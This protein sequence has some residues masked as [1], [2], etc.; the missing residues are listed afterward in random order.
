MKYFMVPCARMLKFEMDWV[1][2]TTET[3]WTSNNIS[4]RRRIMVTSYKRFILCHE[5]FHM[6]LQSRIQGDVLREAAL[7][8]L[9]L[10]S[11]WFNEILSSSSANCLNPTSLR[12]RSPTGLRGLSLTSL[13]GLNPTSLRGLSPTSLRGLSPPALDAW[14]TPA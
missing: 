13:R 3:T 4:I 12:G 10:F 7:P 2:Q 11:I 1:R 9:S 14:T 6:L 8:S 5:A